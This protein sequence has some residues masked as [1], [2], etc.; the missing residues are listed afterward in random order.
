MNASNHKF[1]MEKIIELV[2]KWLITG[3]LN[4]DMLSAD[5]KFV[6]PFWKS[7]TKT[8]FVNKFQDPTVYQ[9]VS[10]SKIIKFD[11]LIRLKG[12][13]GKHFAIA[14]QYHTKNGN[15]VDEVVYGKVSD[16]GLLTKLHSIYDLEAT[17]KALEL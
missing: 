6:S 10:L 11:P 14:L 1:S 7:N 4:A 5:F 9:E 15:S 2:E 3:E 8:E 12:L 17:K 16:N 13:D